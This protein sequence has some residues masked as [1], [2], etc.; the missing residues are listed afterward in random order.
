MCLASCLDELPVL[1]ISCCMY[2]MCVSMG[3]GEC[4]GDPCGGKDVFLSKRGQESEN[5]ELERN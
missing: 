3:T 1:D 4:Y 2:C 5:E